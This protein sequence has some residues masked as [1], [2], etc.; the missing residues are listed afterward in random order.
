[1]KRFLA[2]EGFNN[3]A[4]RGILIRIPDLDILTVQEPG[5]RSWPDDLV[6]KWAADQHRVVLSHDFATMRRSADLR[7]AAGLPM[8]GLMLIPWIRDVG[9]IV[10]DLETAILCTRDDEWATVVFVRF[11]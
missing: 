3:V 7:V 10:E 4:L 9:R 11:S 5:L 6:L 2:D 8:A 1:V